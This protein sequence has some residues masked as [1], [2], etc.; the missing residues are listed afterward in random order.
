MRAGISSRVSPAPRGILALTAL[1]IVV[2]PLA[3][4]R[5]KSPP[6]RASLA[7]QISSVTIV[8]WSAIGDN[9]P[10][11]PVGHGLSD[12][13]VTARTGTTIRRLDGR[14]GAVRWTRTMQYP[15][16]EHR[17]TPSE[18]AWR[19]I[20]ATEC[21]G[22]VVTAFD[23]VTGHSRWT[24]TVPTIADENYVDAELYVPGLGELT[25]DGR[26]DLAILQIAYDRPLIEA[27]HVVGRPSHHQA[28]EGTRWHARLA[29]VDGRTGR[30][31]LREIGTGVGAPATAGWASGR[32]DTLVVATP[33]VGATNVVAIGRRQWTKSLGVTANDVAVLPLRGGVAIV[34][35]ASW[36]D[37]TATG[38]QLDVLT[39][40]TGASRWTSTLP[41]AVSLA[42]DPDGDLM[43][44]DV[45]AHTLR[46]L[47]A[48]NGTAR[49][50][51]DLSGDSPATSATMV[52]LVA[53]VDGHGVHD[54][55]VGGSGAGGTTVLSA[56]TGQQLATIGGGDVV[57]AIGD[58]TGDGRP[59]LVTIDGSTTPATARLRRGYDAHVVWTAHVTGGQGDVLRATLAGGRRGI[60]LIAASGAPYQALD[61]STG[62]RRWSVP[63]GG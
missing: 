31:T 45:T 13:V 36:T 60:L 20:A 62:R 41:G 59:D 3:P 33:A 15:E 1:L 32:R 27:A 63:S 18:D 43:T 61:P 6:C 14:S 16:T 24:A 11:A 8:F 34:R 51:T 46:R 49:W 39:D 57:R 19:G 12:V 53:D 37:Y 52:S 50:E 47:R 56:E 42:A 9:A 21:G 58:V 38:V 40:T 35:S 5:A 26:Q 23:P 29:V 2:G 30:V 4:A 22:A 55:T 54:I 7:G 28:P 25:G 44:L 48:D 17:A 10:E